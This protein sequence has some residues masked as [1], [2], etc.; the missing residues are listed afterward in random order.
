[1]ESSPTD[2]S[3]LAAH[4]DMHALVSGIVPLL[5]RPVPLHLDFFSGAAAGGVGP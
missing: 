5:R 1:M 2:V 3:T 4:P